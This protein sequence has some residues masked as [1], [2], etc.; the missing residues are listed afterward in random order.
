[1]RKHLVKHGDGSVEAALQFGQGESRTES[2]GIV[3]DPHFA[4]LRD[5]VDAHHERRPAPAEVDL[6]T[7]VRRAG[8][9]DRVGTLMHQLE[10]R[11]RSTAVRTPRRYWRFGWLAKPAQPRSGA[12]R[13]DRRQR[14]RLGRRQHPDRPVPRAAAE[15]AAHRVQVEAVRAMFGLVGC[16][17]VGISSTTGAIVLS[18]HRA[19]E[20][21]C[22]VAA[23][24]AAAQCHL[25]L[26][27]MKIVGRTQTLCGEHVLLSRLA[28]G[29][30][31]ALMQTHSVVLSPVV[32]GRATRIAHAPHSLG[33]TSLAPVKP[34]SRIQSSAEVCGG[35]LP[36]AI[37]RPDRCVRCD[38]RLTLCPV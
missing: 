6:D 20:T 37:V 31:Q 22:A 9:E 24:R 19:D 5:L 30:R 38:H 32:L 27:R 25:T 15:V 4:Q 8:H 1:M 34:R 7:P 28:A 16:P 26:D 35:K 12:A 29:M 2:E 13:S 11:V 18:G 3:V 36:K 33:T 14:A 17:G 21:R 10:G 23:L